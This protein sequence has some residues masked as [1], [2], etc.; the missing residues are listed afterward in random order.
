MP[1][2]NLSIPKNLH[3]RVVCDKTVQNKGGGLLMEES[4]GELRKGEG[5]PNF[6]HTDTWLYW[7][8]KGHFDRQYFW[9]FDYQSKMQDSREQKHKIPYQVNEMS[10]LLSCWAIWLALCSMLPVPSQH[11]R[12]ELWNMVLYAYYM[13]SESRNCLFCIQG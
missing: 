2:I 9:L 12:K 8:R 7:Y 11:E 13:Q 5:R 1:K 3:V 10:F 6:I 4:N